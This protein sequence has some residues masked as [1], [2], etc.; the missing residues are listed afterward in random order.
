MIGDR[1]EEYNRFHSE[2]MTTGTG[3]N[4]GVPVPNW[5]FTFI[6]ISNPEDLPKRELYVSI[7]E[8]ISKCELITPKEY[9]GNLM[10]LSQER[11]GIFVNQNF[12]D[13]ER[14]MLTYELPMSELISDFYDELKSLSSGYASMNYEFL[15]YKEDDLVKLDF[16]IAGEKVDALSMMCHRTQAQNIGGKITKK[17]KEV[18]PR[19]LFTIALQATVWGKVVAREDIS[20]LRKDV[21]AKLYGWDI[22]RKR[23]LLDKQKEGK[24]KMKQFWKVSLPSEVFINLLKK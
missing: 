14:I 21:T 12:L 15:K 3:T 20:A 23:K 8:P 11:R 9:V 19:A 5:V 10:K 22:S 4:Q 1:R 18:V 17:L 16:L 2:L 24:K 13:Q 7:E 6:Y